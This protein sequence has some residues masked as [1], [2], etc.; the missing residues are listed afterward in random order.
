MG[1]SITPK[2]TFREEIE[3]QMPI[4]TALLAFGMFCAIANGVDRGWMPFGIGNGSDKAASARVS[5][6][7]APPTS[8]TAPLVAATRVVGNHPFNVRYASG[9]QN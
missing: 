1:T 3:M 6:S 2:N 7:T 5:V 9:A 8:K 4:W